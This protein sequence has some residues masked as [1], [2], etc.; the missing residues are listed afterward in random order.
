[1]DD[2]KGALFSVAGF[3]VDLGVLTSVGAVLGTGLLGFLS[4]VVARKKNK[5]SGKYLS[6]ARS[7]N[8]LREISV[9]R[10]KMDKDLSKGKIDHVLISNV[11]NVLQSKEEK[12]QQN[13]GANEAKY[14]QPPP[15]TW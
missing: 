10:T 12:M 5:R 4:Y 1:Q 9:L 3:D 2:S 6:L 13:L 7:A 15:R 11:E 8:N 14:N